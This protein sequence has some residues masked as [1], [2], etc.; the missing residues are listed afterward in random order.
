MD[1]DK[2]KGDWPGGRARLG[3]SRSY[4]SNGAVGDFFAFIRP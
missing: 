4:P 3:G 1:G 2:G